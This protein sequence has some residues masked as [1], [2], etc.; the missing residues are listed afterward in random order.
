MPAA[1]VRGPEESEVPTSGQLPAIV[2]LLGLVLVVHLSAGEFPQR[3]DRPITGVP[4]LGGSAGETRGGSRMR[5]ES[6]SR[7][8]RVDAERDPP[9]VRAVRLPTELQSGARNRAGEFGT[10]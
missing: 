2:P 7:G 9:Q 5:R 1:R 4:L 6:P 8:T 3:T 10:T